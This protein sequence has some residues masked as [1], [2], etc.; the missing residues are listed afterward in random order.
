MPHAPY[1]NNIYYKRLAK[2]ALVMP[3]FLYPTSAPIAIKCQNVCTAVK[4]PNLALLV[5]PC[6]EA[7]AL[8]SQMCIV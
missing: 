4:W 6:T 2:F 3:F 1:H 5:Y 8:P 7:S